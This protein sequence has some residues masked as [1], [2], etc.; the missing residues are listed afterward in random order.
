VSSK[1]LAWLAAPNHCRFRVT[2]NTDGANAR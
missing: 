1:R 2:P